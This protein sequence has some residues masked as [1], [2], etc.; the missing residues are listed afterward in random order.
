MKDKV[1]VCVIG[2][3]EMAARV[4]YPSLASFDDVEIAG[5]CELDRERLEQAGDAFHIS[6]ERRYHVSRPTDYQDVVSRLDPDGVYV[7]GQPHLM[8]DVWHWCL[9]QGRNLYIEKPMGLNWHQAQMLA[10]VA[11]KNRC[12]T[13]VS[14][15]RRTVPLLHNVRNELLKRGPIVHAMVEFYKCNIEPMTGPRDHMMDDCTHS[16]DTARWICGGE[17]VRVESH[18]KRIGTPDINWIGATLHFDNGAT[19]FVVNSWSSGR[20]VFRVQMHTPGGYTD[21]E[22]EGKARL[23]LDGDYDGVE[24]DTK[25][26]AGSEQFFV[27][28]GFRAKNRE[29]IDSLKA[30]K[31]LTSSPFRDTLETMRVCELILANALVAGE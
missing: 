5:V 22:V 10:H 14:H 21:A 7:I 1:R 31:E 12:I 20:R 4:H 18:C 15:Q 13:Q 11:R 19:C 30:G 28:G 26:V 16:V 2:A 24:L 9:E 6:P 23:Y 3:G 25:D 8:Y 17:V 29:F 27:Y